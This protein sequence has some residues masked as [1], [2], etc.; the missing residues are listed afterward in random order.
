[1]DTLRVTIR[2]RASPATIVTPS[3]TSAARG[4]GT[5]SWG[6]RTS[7]IPQ[8]GGVTHALYVL[9]GGWPA[10]GK[11]TLAGGVARQLQLPLLSK[12]E[13]KEAI[14]DALG[15]PSSVAESQQLGRAAVMAMLR[16]ARRCP[17]GA[18]LD[19]TWYPYTLPLVHE[20]QGDVV[21]VRCLL[22]REVAKARYLARA[23]GRH[24]GHLDSSRSEQELW[25]RLVDPL[26]VGP[27]IEVDTS[28]PVDEGSLARIVLARVKKSQT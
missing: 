26:G 8:N 17:A 25:G 1:M 6:P 9:V 16:I 20:L 14:A 2:L 12:D 13:I 15:H 28:A 27:L 19:S 5:Y 23:G 7:P 4:C 18:V 21:E 10:S 11:S 22:P 24:R 3:V